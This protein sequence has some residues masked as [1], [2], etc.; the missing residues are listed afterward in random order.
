VSF[1]EEGERDF[2]LLKR[3]LKGKFRFNSSLLNGKT[4]TNINFY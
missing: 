2:E 1:N 3:F 4:T